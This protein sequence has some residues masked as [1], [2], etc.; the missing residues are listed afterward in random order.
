[1]IEHETLDEAIRYRI[2]PAVDGKAEWRDP[3]TLRFTPAAPLRPGATYTVTIANDFAAMD[4]AHW[5][6]QMDLRDPALVILHFGMEGVPGA[7]AVTLS[8]KPS[9]ARAIGPLN[10]LRSTAIS[11]SFAA[12][13][14]S[15]NPATGSVDYLRTRA[16][17][18]LEPALDANYRTIKR[19]VY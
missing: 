16:A 13:G 3:V 10:V 15:V 19:T 14:L 2:E 4:G 6:E 18:A 17:I 1:M 11:I 7:W 12:P 5:K 8:G 9:T